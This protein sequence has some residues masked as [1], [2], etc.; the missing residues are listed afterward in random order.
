M[1]YPYSEIE[2]THYYTFSLILTYSNLSDISLLLDDNLKICCN[3][4]RKPS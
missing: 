4:F 2:A 3:C 1:T